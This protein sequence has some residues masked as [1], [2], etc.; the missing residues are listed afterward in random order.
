MVNVLSLLA[1]LGIGFGAAIQTSMLGAMGRARGPSEA[2]WLSV[3]GTVLGLSAV[4]AVRAARGDTPLLPPPFDR[5]TIYTVIAI[6]TAVGIALATRGIAPYFAVTGLFG[7]AF[8]IGAATIGP[9]LGI[10]LFISAA[11]AGQLLGAVALDAVGA[12]GGNVH[13]ITPLRVA[14]ATMLLAGVALVRGFGR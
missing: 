2:A 1:A 12:F 10:A 13:G 9:R 3:L 8:I 14:G 5:G 6:G 11:I 4:L 7:L